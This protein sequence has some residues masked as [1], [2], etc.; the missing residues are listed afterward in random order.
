MSLLALAVVCILL[1]SSLQETAPAELLIELA[2]HG[3]QETLVREIRLHPD[4]TREALYSILRRSVEGTVQSPE[5]SG[6]ESPFGD[7]QLADRLARAYFDVWSDPFLLQEV[8]RFRDWPHESKK[9]K[10]SADSLR[11]VGN[12]AFLTSGVQ[13]ALGL[14]R[15]SLDIS[16]RL[17]DPS[18]RAKT[19]GNIGAGFYVGGEPDSAKVYLTAAYTGATEIG[20]FR[21]AAGA[22]TNLANLALDDG[23][24]SEAAD[25]YT[26]SLT[27]LARTGEHRHL[28]AA[29]HNLAVVSM[30]L[31]DLVGARE[32][33]QQSIQLSR[34]HGYPGDEAEGL[35]TL[36]DLAQAEGNYE[37]AE[38]HLERALTLSREA[39]VRVAEAGVVHSWGLLNAA[40]GAYREAERR[41]A[42]ARDLYRDLGRGPDLVVALQDLARVK[43]ATG[44]IRGGLS[45]IQL[46]EEVAGSAELGGLARADLALTSAEVSLALNDYPRARLLFR[47]AGDFYR[48]ANDVVGEAEALEGEAFLS[49]LRDDF[50]EARGGFQRAL[51]LRRLETP[52]DPRAIG[53]TAM[54]LAAVEVELGE[55]SAARAT[56]ERVR[57]T[58]QTL[59]DPVGEAA[60]LSA[61]GG[62]EMDL[63]ARDSAVSLFR[64]G[65][66]LLEATPAPEV[67]WRIRAGLAEAQ[68][69]EGQFREA[70]DQLLRAMETIQAA[71]A[72]LSMAD[73][74]AFLSDKRS[75]QHRL[76]SVLLSLGELED[77]FAVSE[78]AR[79][80]Q[81]RNA[82]RR[83]S[84]ATPPGIPEAL[85]LRRR[86]LTGRIDALTRQLRWGDLSRSRLRE[87]FGSMP[88]SEASV[89]EALAEAYVEYEDLLGRMRSLAPDGGTLF[90]ADL[91]S[92]DDLQ[93]EIQPTQA[94]LEYLVG[95]DGVMVFVLTS[96]T[97]EGLALDLDPEAVSDLI[98]FARGAIGAVGEREL[99]DSWRAP[100]TRLHGLLI[101]PVEETGLLEDRS[102]LLILAH[103]ALH[104][105]PF[106]ALLRPSDDRF[107][108]ERYSVSYA[109]SASGWLRLRDRARPNREVE[110]SRPGRSSAPSR[111]I[112][113]M[114]PRVSELPGSRYEVEVI[115]RLFGD[116]AEVL[117]GPDASEEVFRT[118]SPEF[119][120]IHLATYGR[121]NKTNPLFS[122]VELAGS[123]TNPG[124]LEVHEVFDLNLRARLL[125][126]SA[127]ESGLG[128]G[129]ISDVP[130]GDDWVG[131]TTAFLSAGADNVLASLWQV[132]DLATAELMQSFYRHLAVEEDF[133]EALASAQRELRSKPDTSHPFYWAGFQL[134]GGGGGLR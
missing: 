124:F 6:G 94:V 79:I 11:L 46:A 85:H 108:I 56:F 13:E 28:S 50:Q 52:A 36:A 125:A 93:S 53:L 61:W 64:D 57:E 107:L 5:L 49:F 48:A 19:E 97:L 117:L 25:L 2:M 110:V 40:R 82:I 81:A 37:E 129:G 47:R 55:G 42:D 134:I 114:A 35:S 99:V 54:Y 130:P 60:V 132:D 58:M 14:W 87:A 39:G 92:V 126:L 27:I 10:L 21:T 8:D 15:K 59:G 70:R 83:G 89:R 12:E 30:A 131:L 119:E 133:A 78:Q 118:R 7:L 1:P 100:L 86:D 104:Y 90:D 101:R 123:D 65:L 112:L 76:A 102:S 31:G 127:C 33:L 16:N 113:A 103:G 84:T 20:D 109:P 26:Q 96:D 17:D 68:M 128:S 73:R 29:Q 66:R 105:L 98:G 4:G 67:E 75:V 95:E 63:G 120:M 45:V 121:L 41:L 9:L 51:S 72:D 74:M 44:D 122:F 34:L 115:G 88:P 38:Q 77:G 22:A 80:G 116:G 111:T 91:V 23:R 3:D 69:E 24:L 71:S 106:Q 62:L 18:G 43:T 32:A